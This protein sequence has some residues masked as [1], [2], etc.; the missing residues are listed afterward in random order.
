MKKVIP[1]ALAMMITTGA[2]ADNSCKE[3][4]QSKLTKIE[5]RPN[6]NQ[7]LVVVGG[8]SFMIATAGLL[9][10]VTAAPF[11]GM[12]IAGALPGAV[13]GMTI[14]EM[15]YHRQDGIKESYD[16]QKQMTVSYDEL[17]QAFESN[18]QEILKRALEVYD[19]R[20]THQ[21]YAEGIVAAVNKR[22][23]EINKPAL[24]PSE[25]LAYKRREITSGILSQKLKIENS[26]S[27]SLEIAKKLT[28]QDISYE[29]WRLHM[30]SN[31]EQFCPNGKAITLKKATKNLVDKY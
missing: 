9:T 19:V 4:Y 29:A 31:E 28:N 18:R 5:Q 22:R 3:I 2:F 6:R 30:L 8:V 1:L 20:I 21:P 24:S 13:G 23:F 27:D 17:L 12:L 7:V 26:V 11:L 10:A 15:L 16:A 14:D 25:A